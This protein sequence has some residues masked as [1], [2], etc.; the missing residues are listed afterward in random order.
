[1]TVQLNDNNK[2][3]AGTNK[4]TVTNAVAGEYIVAVYNADKTIAKVVK[5]L[6][7]TAEQGQTAKLFIWDSMKGMKPVHNC[8][9]FGF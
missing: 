3:A 2:L 9:S 7:F 5:G 8:Y 1:M 4:I 6:E